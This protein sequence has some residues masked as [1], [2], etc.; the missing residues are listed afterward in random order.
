M[1]A[2]VDYMK[3]LFKQYVCML[4]IL[5]ILSGM[6]PMAVFATETTGVTET[7]EMTDPT[8]GIETTDAAE[9]TETTA[10]TEA[11]AV[12]GVTEVTEPTESNELV[13]VHEHEYLAEVTD[14]TCTEQGYTVYTCDCG[15]CYV[16]NYMDAT[17]LHTYENVICIHCGQ[18]DFSQLTYVAFGDSITYGVDGSYRSNE[19]GWIMS[20]PYPKL[21]GQLLNFG[22]VKNEGVSGGTLCADS[23]R[24]NM[25]ERILRFNGKVNVIS[26]M[27]G[28]NDYAV[29]CPMGDADSTDNK[30]IFGSLNLICQHLT[31]N[32]PNALVFFMT[33]FQ[34]RG[35]EKD[36]GAGYTL[37]AVADAVKT[38]AARYQIPVLDMYTYGRFEEEFND[39][40]LAYQDGIHPSQQHHI[41]YTAP[42]VA[43]FIT[44]NYTAPYEDDSQNDSV[45]S[46]GRILYS[47]QDLVRGYCTKDG[48]PVANSVHSYFTMDAEGIQ[49]ITITPPDAPG[50][51]PLDI[52]YIVIV[53]EDGT[54]SCHGKLDKQEPTVIDLGGNTKG[55]V[56]F[57]AF[58]DDHPEYVYVKEAVVTVHEHRHETVVT[59][60]TCTEK[61]YST[62]TCECGD[63]YVDDYVDAGGHNYQNGICSI[64]GAED[65]STMQS[66]S[67]RYDD[68][69]DIS[70]REVAIQDA[71]KPSSYQV[72]YGVEENSVL[73]TA[74][75]TVEGNALVA[76]GI[77]VARVRIDGQLYEVTVTAAP[78]SLL[79]LAGQSNMQ[80]I[81]G[82]ASESVVCPTGQVYATYADRYKK[83]VEDVTKFAPS[84]LAGQYSSVN[85]TGDAACLENFPVN[86]LTEEGNGREGMDSGLAYEWARQTGEK[87]WVIN[88]GYGGSSI[89]E[90]LD[91]GVHYEACFALFTACQETLRK[92][93]AA[94]H[95]TL[96]HMGYFWCQGCAD[97]TQTAQ[98]YV[99][100][101]QTMHQLFKTKLTFDHDSSSVTPEK[102]ME[103]AGIIPIR[104]GHQGAD[105]YR[106]GVYADSTNASYYQS[107]KD[108]RFNGPRVA[109]YWM[110]NNPKLGDIWNVC[111][112]QE[113]WVTMPDGTN[114]V[115]A[116][117]RSV[118][119][120][121]TVDYTPQ[122]A[123]SATWYT[124]TTPAAVHD[125][126]HYNQ[127]GYNE[128]GR[129]SARNALILMGEKEAPDI[130]ATVEFLTW[131]GYT[132]AEKI[133]ASVAGS[134]NTLV[135]PMVSPIWKAKEVTYTVSEGLTYSYYDL[136]ADT[137]RTSGTLSVF[138]AQSSV[139]VSPRELTSYQW[140]LDDTALVSDPLEGD[141]D[142]PLSRLAGSVIDGKFSNIR[143]Q[144]AQSIFLL[145]DQTWGLEVQISNWTAAA[146]S[147]LLSG[148]QSSTDGQP[149]LY[150]RPSDF[151]VGFGY[152]DGAKYHNYG[153]SLKKHGISCDEGA[154]TYRFM[155]R[156][157]EDGS[158]QIWFFV[159]DREIGPL[160]DH[161]INSTFTDA[162]ND[163]I[164]GRD[165][166]MPYFGTS[167]SPV[168]DCT[169]HYIRA[170]EAD[171][172][173]DAHFH[174]WS[175]WET[176]TAPGP[177]GP[178][179]EQRRCACGDTEARDVEGVWQTHELSKYLLTLP[180]SYCAGTN[181]WTI[182]PHT[183][184]YY[185]SGTHWDTNAA[186]DVWSVTIP[187][188]PCDQ[189]FATS[190]GKAGGNGHTS[191]GIRV[192]F[193]D[194]YGVCKTMTPAETYAEFI[195]NGGYL[196]APEG[197][198]AVNIP[199]Y[200]NSDA[201]EL[202][203]LNAEHDYSGTVCTI[204]SAEHP[205]A[206]NYEGKV[207]S[208][209]SASTSTFAGYIPVAD[210]F[211]LAHQARYPQDNLLTDVN[212]TWWMQVIQQLD[213]KLGI[214]DSWAG[215]QVLN[216]QDVN[217]G[218]LGPDAAMASLTR[219]QNLGA[220]GTPDVI[221]FFG[222]GNDMGRSVPLGSFDPAAAPTE[223]DLTATKW[224][225][226]ADAY[227]AAIMRLQ[228]FYPNSRIVVMTSYPMP[229]YVTEA[230]L[231]MY[232]PVI[233]TICDHYGVEY[234]SLRNCGVTFDMLPDNIHPNAEGMDHITNA[235]LTY[236]L[237]QDTLEPGENTVYSVIHKLT[238][239]KA[240]LGYFKGISAG[241]AFA[242]T[243]SGE[244]LTV[245]VTMGRED[246]TD[247]C[248]ADGKISIANVTGDIVITAKG[249]YNVDG[250]LQQLPEIFCAGTNLWKTLKP[251][252]CYYTVNGWEIL[253]PTTA[254]RLPSQS[255]RVTASGQ[256]HWDM[257][258]QMAVRPMVCE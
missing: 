65:P 64:C 83:T 39:S 82:N 121:G 213:A 192:T 205:N 244:E 98:W 151:F 174:Q 85:V 145:H 38:V 163:W 35:G 106:A 255:R 218:D 156:I 4:L 184:T 167:Y 26:I 110:G 44:K 226:F 215:S 25:T 57:N 242:E 61:G 10:V 115:A 84:A 230:K 235:V 135:V 23:G 246:I 138:G 204:C 185:Y 100:K 190:F 152:Y 155:N 240:S 28:V 256:P 198:V 238:N 33:P 196:T 181:L 245:S 18:K 52:Y 56:Y 149:Y 252:N 148:G 74:V 132:T 214:N 188:E 19:T 2:G 70:G 91:G 183:E 208:I 51:N 228:Y 243:L 202:Y 6:M 161:Y 123:Q 77:G 193:F 20:D 223:V 251:E 8:E 24:T 102:C 37:S 125:N 173:P 16:D 75:V 11:T 94:G 203:I 178:G 227:T 126:I 45:E 217:S 109:Q 180:E 166:V 191:N 93:I 162:E 71:G 13:V 211:N 258:P 231:D 86:M 195:S 53:H 90:W 3:T 237:A 58:Y 107:F 186:A 209:L 87:V 40:S 153:V 207:I 241:K 108:L 175:E 27:L 12:A 225:S 136:L 118:Y 63:S 233:Q 194:A 164:S 34:L 116:Y 224:D 172:D 7:D 113:D 67:L 55:T 170:C 41:R 210:G 201:H 131:D 97:E 157:S 169:I 212:E 221:L 165:F 78:I 177:D 104:S 229:G 117:F 176:V 31:E 222:G 50:W 21:V 46:N 134:S 69:Y 81:D 49:T 159:D 216:T 76:T 14:P 154:H 99:E 247:T 42:M 29:C 119:E 160:T 143:Y 47:Q 147:M 129:E 62:H 124:P 120:N 249:S 95:F 128:I 199:M 88:L 68:H 59:E 127:I 80:G 32:Y 257:F 36:R 114:G 182:L 179:K 141:T 142:N 232:G 101:F 92:E 150:F 144:A 236:L 79:L 5:G 54:V 158:N 72:G 219:I 111:T 130:R 122:V 171:Y 206:A 253:P 1:D 133:I 248:Y 250:H 103:F 137:V 168:R 140:S 66:M 189:I 234:L 15:D 30:T 239:T 197:T 96:S 200:G 43:E 146:G 187:V 139:D 254:G 73:D 112:I 17:G 220:N 9:S 22:T 105:S 89:K 48:K 60:P